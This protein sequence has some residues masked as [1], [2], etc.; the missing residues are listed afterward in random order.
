MMELQ[1]AEVPAEREMSCGPTSGS[2]RMLG[3]G[4]LRMLGVQHPQIPQHPPLKASLDNGTS[5]K[6]AMGK[7]DSSF[8][9]FIV[10]HSSWFCVRHGS[11]SNTVK[12]SFSGP[13]APKN[14]FNPFFMLE[15]VVQE[16]TL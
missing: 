10:R 4:S 6:I 13:S 1:D 15:K 7:M 16:S 3:S 5:E 14:K 12:N 2:I 9:W 8:V 11:A